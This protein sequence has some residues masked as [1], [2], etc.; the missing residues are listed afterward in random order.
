MHQWVVL[1]NTIKI[2][3]KTAPTCFGTFYTIITERI[4]SCLIKLRI[5][6]LPG[7]GVKCSE[8]CQS[9]FNVNFHIVFLRQ[10]TGASVGE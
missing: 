9:C 4:N 10:L 1:K 7:D 2:Y 8:T 6:A 5:N 3:I